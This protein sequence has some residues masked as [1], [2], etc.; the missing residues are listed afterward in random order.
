M[1]APVY[2]PAARAFAASYVQNPPGLT[3]H[4]LIV[5]LNGTTPKGPLHDKL[6]APLAPN[7]LVYNNFGKDLGLFVHAAD[8]L[9]CDLL[10][11]M[12]AHINFHL[13]GW[14]DIIMARYLEFGPSFYGA[15]GFHHPKPHIRTTC[16]WCPPDLLRLYPFAISDHTRYEAEHGSNSFA[17]WSKSVGFEPMMVTRRGCFKMDEWHHVERADCL[18]LDQHCARIG[19]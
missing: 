16:F 17:L 2:H 19:Y 5:G 8:V 7:F 6:F 18:F 9:E 10:V 14:L 1:N 3:D 11:C 13:P 12:G 4:E 15:W